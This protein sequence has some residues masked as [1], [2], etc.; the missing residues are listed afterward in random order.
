MTA[1]AQYGLS[2][3]P[4]RPGTTMVG[5]TVQKLEVGSTGATIAVTRT[6]TWETSPVVAR[7][8][9]VISNV[10]PTC[11][12]NLAAVCVLIATSITGSCGAGCLPP[13]WPVMGL[14]VLGL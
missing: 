8:G 10:E 1:P 6:V 3:G 14:P 7:S 12:R 4:W 11:R 9:P 13:G 5:S 2:V